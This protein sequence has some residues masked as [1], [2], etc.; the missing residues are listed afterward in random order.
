QSGEVWGVS[1]PP[2]AGRLTTG[3][4]WLA[5]VFCVAPAKREKFAGGSRIDG[6]SLAAGQYGGP[7]G[8]GGGKHERVSSGGDS[9]RSSQRRTSDQ[10]VAVSWVP[11]LRR[12]DD[13]RR[14]V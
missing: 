3:K 5:N 10:E 9:E 7:S 11:G 2:C 13:R 14:S 8:S 6:Y 4:G 1:I 12:E